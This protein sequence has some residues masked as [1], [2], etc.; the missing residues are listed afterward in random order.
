MGRKSTTHLSDL[1]F[2][3]YLLRNFITEEGD[4]IS[5]RDLFTSEEFMHYTKY[6]RIVNGQK[7][8]MAMGTISCLLNKLG[9]NEDYMFKYYKSKGLIRE[10]MD[11]ETWTRKNNRNRK[12]NR[13]YKYVQAEFKE[14]FVEYF[15]LGIRN[16]DLSIVDL[17]MM[18]IERYVLMGFCEEDF[19]EDYEA[20]K[21]HY[22]VTE[23]ALIES[24]HINKST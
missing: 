3:R 12:H 10:D 15:K 22:E 6:Y 1:Q 16:A 14:I 5:I 8:P 18:A 17:K 7:Q 2:K 19:I 4:K 13:I 11:F 24:R 21:E 23:R 20:L 9:L